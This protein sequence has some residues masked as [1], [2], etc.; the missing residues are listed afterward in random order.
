MA[1]LLE[2]RAWRAPLEWAPRAA[3]AMQA[4]AS[5][6]AHSVGGASAEQRNNAGLRAALLAWQRCPYAGDPP[7]HSKGIGFALP[8][9]SNSSPGEYFA[10][11]FMNRSSLDEGVYAYGSD[12]VLGWPCFEGSFRAYDECA[13]SRPHTDGCVPHMYE[14]RGA[15]A[16]ERRP[17]YEQARAGGG[18]TGWTEPYTDPVTNEQVVSFVTP[19]DCSEGVIICGAWAVGAP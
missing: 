15:Y 8:A 6:W 13:V 7:L 10:V 9:A 16:V 2:R 1:A 11:Y 3:A 4:S 14:W 18:W 17:W 5:E 12:L 19:L